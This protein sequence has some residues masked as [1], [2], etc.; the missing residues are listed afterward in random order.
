M[1]RVTISDNGPGFSPQQREQAF[2]PFYTTK[3]EGTGLGL[4]ISRRIVDLHDGSIS[5]ESKSTAGAEIV[6]L[7]PAPK[8]NAPCCLESD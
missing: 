8:G 4:A 5:I 1:V 6:L 2:E 3:C 7:L